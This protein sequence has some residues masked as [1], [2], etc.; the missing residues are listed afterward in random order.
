MEPWEPPAVKTAHVGAG[1]SREP[2][3]LVIPN[4]A[5]FI[6]AEE[7]QS[8]LQ[9]RASEWLATDRRY[10][11]SFTASRNTFVCRSTSSASVCGDISAIL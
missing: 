2:P 6:A 4:A 5:F 1:D 3:R 7:S 11:N 8:S 9:S 10:A